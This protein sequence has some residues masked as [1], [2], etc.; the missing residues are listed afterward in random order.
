MSNLNK[1]MLIGHLG[2]EMKM[3]HFEGGGCIGRVPMATSEF[4]NDKQSGERKQHTEWHNLLF[5]NKSAENFQKYT[6]KGSKVYVEGKLR[7]RKWQ[8]DGGNDR[9]S[10]EINV[11]SF[12]FLDSKNQSSNN[13]SPVS[14]YHRNNEQSNKTDDLP[15]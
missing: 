6:N 4:W 7:T 13:T 3:H 15:F 9:Y 2:D 8:D 11:I 1:V 12:Q 10:T 5:R 14:E